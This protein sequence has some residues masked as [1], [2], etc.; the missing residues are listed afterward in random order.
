MALQ[1]R[2]LC[3]RGVP[4]QLI[5]VGKAHHGQIVF[6]DAMF[7]FLSGR[8]SA[9]PFSELRPVVGTTA[10]VQSEIIK[11]LK[12]HGV[13]YI[14]LWSEPY[15]V[16]EPDRSSESSV[17]MLN[18]FI[19]TNYRQIAEYDWYAI[20]YRSGN[21]LVRSFQVLTGTEFLVRCINGLK[22]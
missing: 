7:Y 4:D 6:N 13:A 3:Q 20:F 12:G 10:K 22:R 18:D 2:P 8:S 16:S 17:R 5:C 19:R 14:V 11:G 1:K 9:T 21:A 15:A